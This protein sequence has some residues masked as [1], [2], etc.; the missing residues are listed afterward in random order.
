MVERELPKLLVWVRFPSPARLIQRMVLMKKWFKL[1]VSL[2]VLLLIVLALALV[3]ML[4]VINPQHLKS[5][6]INVFHDQTEYELV[7]PGKLTWSFYPQLG[8]KADQVYVET[9]HKKVLLDAREVVF[10]TGY[11]SSKTPSNLVG[12]MKMSKLHYLGLSFEEVAFDFDWQAQTLKI[13]ELH[14]KFYQGRLDASLTAQK[15]SNQPHWQYRIAAHDIQ[16]APLLGDLLEQKIKLKLAGLASI[17]FQGETEGIDRV[18]WLNQ[19]NGTGEC[20]I[21]NG[22]LEGVDIDYFIQLAEAK[23]LRDKTKQHAL[24]NTYQTKFN[25]MSATF[26]IHNGIAETNNL[27]L[28]SSALLLSASGNIELPTQNIDFQAEVKPLLD[29]KISVRIPLKV[30]NNLMQ[31]EIVLENITLQHLM[32]NEQIKNVKQKTLEKID[33]HVH[34]KAGAFLKNL[35]R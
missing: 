24:T 12:H 15:L 4:L 5:M 30:M 8:L 7:I 11:L 18:T 32:T 33:K 19:L 20:Y 6:L 10:N 27:L 28:R 21:K 9:E 2:I 14:A 1:L 29:S 16:L 31:P 26:F 25:D 34:G 13:N 35:F 23:I 3:V 22:S 17:N